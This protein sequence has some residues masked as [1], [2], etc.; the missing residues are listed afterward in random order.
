MKKRDFTEQKRMLPEFPSTPHL[1]WK[2][3]GKGIQVS[4]QEASILWTSPNVIVEEK[5]DG[6]SAGMTI[7]DEDN[8]IIRNR[9]FILVKGYEKDTP[10]KKQFKPIW[11][12]WYSHK[13]KFMELR[14]CGPYSVY[15]EWMYMAHGMQYDQLPSMFITYELYDYEQ[16]FFVDPFQARMILGNCGFVAVKIISI[17][18]LNSWEALVQMANDKSFYTSDSKREG[19]YV[20]VGDGKQITN[21]FKMVREDFVQGALFSDTI[22]KNQLIKG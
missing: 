9:D 3:V 16:G 11:N 12:W 21:R 7:D 17:G 22:I 18:A 1:P 4:E 6:A 15:G 14:L 10:A 20:K 19:V 8:P 13:T 2:C 5:I